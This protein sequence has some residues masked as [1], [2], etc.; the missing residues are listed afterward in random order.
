MARTRSEEHE[1]PLH[2]RERRVL[3]LLGMPTFALALAITAVT[4][5]APLL[6]RRHT[7]STTVIGVII[8]AEGFVA[9]IVP[10]VA[11][12]WSDQ[13]RTRVGGRLPFIVAGAPALAAA[14]ILMSLT[15]S[16][17]V[18]AVLVLVFFVAYYTAYEP[19]RALYPD[20]LTAEVAGR[21]QSTQALFRGAA[22]G[23]ALIG[24]GLLFGLSAQ[25]PFMIFALLSLATLVAFVWGI[26]GSRA[27][28]E[29]EEHEARTARQTAARMLALLR[30]RPAMRA[31][32]IANAL[33]ELSLAALKT[34]IM[35]FL[36]VGIGLALPDAVAVIAVVMALILIS[37]ALSGRLGDRFGRARVVRLAAPVYG[38]GLLVPLF[39]Q[40]MYVVAPIV[41]LIAFG[42]GMVLTLPYAILMPLMPDDDHGLL[43]GFY[44]FSR[45][46]GILLGPL[47]AGVAITVLRP[48]LSSTHGYAAM[49][50]VCGASM[51]ASTAFVEPLRRRE[52]RERR[53]DSKPAAE[54]RT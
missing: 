34:F 38:C 28:R 46:I 17:L 31:F 24:G 7:S 18:L 33:W 4:T 14:M 15:S 8:A 39:T 23:T 20:L 11:G 30:R 29:Q 45:G 40:S 47:L 41:A 22:T 37:A 26:K 36:T 48:L 2:G 25:L 44:S 13:L 12:A 54:G 49:W 6:A 42:G 9:L 27:L 5:Y 53:R 3:A 43:T 19:Y 50:L 21:G 52:A 35:L 16:L 10:L 32:L 1:R 51:L